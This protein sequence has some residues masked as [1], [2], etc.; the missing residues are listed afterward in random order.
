MDRASL[1]NARRRFAHLPSCG[2]GKKRGILL[3]VLFVGLAGGLIWML[4]R[5]TEPAYQGKRLSAWLSEY[6]ANGG[7]GKNNQADVAFREMGTKAIP[8]LLRII[9]SDDPPFQR[10]TSELNRMQ[11]LVHFPV[12]EAS[13]LRWA[14]TFALYAMGTNAESALPALTNLLFRSNAANY[15]LLLNSAISLAG[16]G[17]A[18]LPPLLAALTNQNSSIRAAAAEALRWERSDLNLVIPAL[19]AR[20]NQENDHEMH[21]HLRILDT[22]GQLHAEPGLAVPALMTDFP[23]DD[24]RRRREI[25]MSLGQ[26]GAKASAAVPMILEALSDSDASVRKHAA[27]ALKRIDPAAAAKAGLE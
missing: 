10:M 6:S 26:F 4:S 12:R 8:W 25:L 18:G 14:A 21:V 22:L 19:V 1:E 15:L 16:M 2:M 27:L 11:S 13:K 24:P 7:P 9:R 17:T 20:L 23:G 5:L 3:G